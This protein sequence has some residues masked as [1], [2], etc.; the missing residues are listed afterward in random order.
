MKSNYITFFS[1]ISIFASCTL[2]EQPY[3]NEYIDKWTGIYEGDVISYSGAGSG[4]GHT[5]GYDT[6]FVVVIVNKSSKDT[7]INITDTLNN[8]I[9][10][11]DIPINKKGQKKIYFNGGYLDVTFEGKLLTLLYDASTKNTQDRWTAKLVKN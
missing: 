1:F 7:S 5:G 3:P 4:T 10:W 11:K 9:N 2:F 8:R 6:S